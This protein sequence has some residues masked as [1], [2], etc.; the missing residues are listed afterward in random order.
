MARESMF[1]AG[2]HQLCS[3]VAQK[4][5]VEREFL[6]ETEGLRTI[7]ALV[8]PEHRF[9]LPRV[10]DVETAGGKDS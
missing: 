5:D 7:G 1:L 2:C 6:G 3:R 9:L 10:T 8:C 4:I